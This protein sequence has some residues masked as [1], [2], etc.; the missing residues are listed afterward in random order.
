MKEQQTADALAEAAVAEIESGMMVGLGTGR[1]ASRGVR[2]LA[3]RVRLHGLEIECVATSEGAEA[4]AKQLHLKVVDF[5]LVEG[6]DYLFDGAD[7]IDRDL[8]ILKGGGGAMTR[9]RMIAWTSSRC[10][11]M[12][13]ESKVSRRLGKN[14]P[15]SIAVMAF[16]MTSIRAALREIG[17]NGVCRRTIDGELFITDNGNLIIDAGI[18]DGADLRDLAATL[19]D[20]P[21]VVDHGLFLE[22]ADEILIERQDGSI[23]RLVRAEK[24]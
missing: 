20:M 10:I 19:N 3:E 24:S 2:A 12:V 6:V 9:E 14:K 5:A 11:Y 15:L 17:L 22:E 23:E 8:N 1:A 16:G 4:L 7:E 18:A 13:D 21:G